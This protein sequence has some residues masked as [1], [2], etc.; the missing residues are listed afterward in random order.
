[1]P[2]VKPKKVVVN[3]MQ[4]ELF[5]INRLAEALGRT[6]QTVR[7]WEIAGVIPKSIFKDKNTGRRMYTQGQIDTIVKCAEDCGIAQG[8][9]IANT[10]FSSKVYK[11]LREHNKMYYKG[12]NT[13]HDKK[14]E[15]KGCTQS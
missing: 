8:L 1:M 12:G 14:E 3:G 4:V 15:S 5:Y 9:S 6:T 7:K 10:S 13:T 2:P 11:A